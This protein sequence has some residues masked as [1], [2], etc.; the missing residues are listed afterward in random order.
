MLDVSWNNT[1]PSIL[2]DM[3]KLREAALKYSEPIIDFRV[4]EHIYNSETFQKYLGDY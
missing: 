3:E 4:P 2:K 1:F